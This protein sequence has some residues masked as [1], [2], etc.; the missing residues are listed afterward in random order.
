MLRKSKLLDGRTVV[1]TGGTRGIGRVIADVYGQAGAEVVVGSSRASAVETT[2]RELREHGILAAGT[3]C[4]VSDLVQ[5]QGLLRVALETFGKVDVWV[6]NAAISGSFGYVLDIPPEEWERV[7][8]VNLLGTYHGTVAVLP[9]MLERGYGKVI[10]LSGGGAKRAQRSLSA[11]STSKAGVVRMTEAFAR[12]Y[13]D[14]PGLSFNVLAPGMVPTDMLINVQAVGAGEE[15]IKQLPKVIEIFGTTA[16]ETAQVA[17][18][19]ASQK[20][21]GVSGKVFE[22]MPRRRI[23]WR[24]ARAALRRRL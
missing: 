5:V 15:T 14:Y 1:I 21:D 6:N 23:I 10:N 3:T 17:L 9:H 12:D 18:R 22:L 24:L 19:M 11:Y 20:T 8:Q 2:V 13:A 4:D 16:E 7:I